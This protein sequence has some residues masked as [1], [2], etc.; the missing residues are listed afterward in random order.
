M[1]RKLTREAAIRILAESGIP[2]ASPDDPI[3][4]R[5]PSTNYITRLG[6]STRT[7]SPNSESTPQSDQTPPSASRTED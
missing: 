1:A 7:P 2:L 4:K 6:A 5:A 3:Y